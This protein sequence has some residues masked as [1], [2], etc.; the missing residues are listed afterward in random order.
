MTAF[1]WRDLEK[2]TLELIDDSGNPR[3]NRIE[4]KLNRLVKPG[5]LAERY[6]GHNVDVC[7]HVSGGETGEYCILLHRPVMDNNSVVSTAG[8][9]EYSFQ[10]RVDQ[11]EVAVFVGVPILLQGPKGPVLMRICSEARLMRF[12]QVL[13]GLTH[14][15]HISR[16]LATPP[17]GIF[18]DGKL[19]SLVRCASRFQ[20]ELP[21]QV[22]KGRPEIVEGVSEH[23][24]GWDTDKFTVN[25]PDLLSCI[26][27]NI[28]DDGIWLALSE[29]FNISTQFTVVHLTP[30]YLDP[31]TAEFLHM[32]Y[33]NYERQE[34]QDSENTQ[35]VRDTDSDQG[36]RTQGAEEGGR[37]YRERLRDSQPP[38]EGLAQTELSPSPDSST[39]KH[40]RLGSPEDA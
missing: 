29:Q 6:A 15:C 39:A 8:V 21:S 30:C 3:L 22:V 19:S 13:H 36:R 25:L 18:E 9:P 12:D 32:L 14:S 11:D 37:A 27:V 24:Q 28:T 2:C 10:T 40:T 31:D 4:H 23:G 5:G 34:T 1:G 33:S 20:D 7:F 26:R 17:S 38:G 35:R 16:R